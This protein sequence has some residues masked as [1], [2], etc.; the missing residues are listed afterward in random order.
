MTISSLITLAKA[1]AREAMR[2][3]SLRISAITTAL[4]GLIL[5]NQDFLLRLIDRVAGEY[6][7]NAIVGATLFL[8]FF[9]PSLKCEFSPVPEPKGQADGGH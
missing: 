2:L 7:R 6:G 5:S 1:D 4:A 8:V 3:I 9:L